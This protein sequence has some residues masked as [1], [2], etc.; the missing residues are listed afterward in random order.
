MSTV[1]KRDHSKEKFDEA[2]IK[3]SIESAARE[4]KLPDEN[5]R[6][7]VDEVSRPVIDCARCEKMI[8]SAA[9][10]DDILNKLDATEPK[11]SRAWRDFEARTK[12]MTC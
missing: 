6:H 10:R 1:V 3:R 5:V 11:V 2:K 9:I 4:T 8:R 7:L 12:G